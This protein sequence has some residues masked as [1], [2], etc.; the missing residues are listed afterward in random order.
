M[1]SQVEVP[2]II[3]SEIPEVKDEIGRLSSRDNIAGA[4]QIVVT[5]V[6]EMLQNHRVTKANWCIAF[7]GW[8]YLKGNEGVR[9]IIENVFVRSFNGMRR[10]CSP[11]EWVIIQQ[12]M[13]ATLYA[14]FVFQNRNI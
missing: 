6:R 2:E 10:L 11:A 1:I 3:A 5:Y 7:V 9:E 13:P 12:R 8:L 14:V 4:M